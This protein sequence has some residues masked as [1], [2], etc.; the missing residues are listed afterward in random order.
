MLGKSLWE[1]NQIR[2][3]SCGIRKILSPIIFRITIKLKELRESLLRY[4]NENNDL[5]YKVSSYLILIK[6]VPIG[7]T[8]FTINIKII[9]GTLSS[10]WLHDLYSGRDE[11]YQCNLY[12]SN[13]KL[14]HMV[15]FKIK[16]AIIR[17]VLIRLLRYNQANLY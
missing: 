4:R 9:A 11:G 2:P 17:S 1:A 10:I 5:Y 3:F 12:I 15:Q 16:Y 14:W 8:V 13:A 7:T 6:R